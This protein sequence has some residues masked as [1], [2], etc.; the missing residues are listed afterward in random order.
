MTNHKAI[1]SNFTGL[2]PFTVGFD[3]MFDHFD[4]L[5]T[6]LP[7]MTA[8]NYPPYNIVKTGSLSYDI[9]V[10]LAGY[11]KKDVSVNY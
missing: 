7:S 1:H 10:A 3:D 9:E 5:T 2:R 11:S 6:Q 8:T 4:M